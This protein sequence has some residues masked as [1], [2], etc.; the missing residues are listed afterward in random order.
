MKIASI[1][2][3][4]VS[5]LIIGAGILTSYLAYDNALQEGIDI[6]NETYSENNDRIITEEIASSVNKIIIDIDYSADINV[7]SG[8]EYPYI[9]MVNYTPYSYIISNSSDS[10]ISISDTISAYNMIISV[11]DNGLRHLLKSSSYSGKDRAINIYLSD[12]NIEHFDINIAS[13]SFNASS[14]VSSSNYSVI[15]EEGNASFSRVYTDSEVY[16]SIKQGDAL[17]S[18]CSIP[19]YNI[20]LD[21]GNF[22]C[23]IIPVGDE[24][25]DMHTPGGNIYLFG[26]SSGQNII[27]EGFSDRKINAEIISGDII[28]S[29]YAGD[30]IIV[31]QPSEE[32]EENEENKEESEET[33]EAETVAPSD[34]DIM[35]SLSKET[36]E[37]TD[38]EE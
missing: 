23:E 22:K 33:S 34:F 26:S 27:S 3:L 5:I 8:A 19:E 29:E 28:I 21:N 35:S 14:V 30:P 38:I 13:G 1:V 18:G 11:K 15:I 10:I 20:K 9:E 4:V 7:F 36:E 2:F 12:N 37:E 17:F 25:F 6:F 31:D 32:T 16:V 24:L